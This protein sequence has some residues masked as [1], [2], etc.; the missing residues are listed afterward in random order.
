MGEIIMVILVL[1]S[2]FTYVC[3]LIMYQFSDKRKWHKVG[4]GMMVGGWVCVM[5]AIL[6]GN[7][8]WGGYNHVQ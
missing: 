3:G 4:F 5:L 2:L 8:I 6:V 7:M 1:F